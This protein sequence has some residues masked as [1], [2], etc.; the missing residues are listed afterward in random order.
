MYR[1]VTGVTS[2]VGVLSTYLVHLSIYIF[3]FAG[4]LGALFATEEESGTL[5]SAILQMIQQ[6]SLSESQ[7]EQVIMM[8]QQLLAVK[9]HLT[10]D[11]LMLKLA[12]ALTAIMGQVEKDSGG[13]CVNF[14]SCWIFQEI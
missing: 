6:S 2:D 12:P 13:K 9:D 4:G 11:E 7:L 14:M 8:V 10:E 3:C 1:I 5:Q